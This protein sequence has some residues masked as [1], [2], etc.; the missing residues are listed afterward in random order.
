MRKDKACLRVTD[1]S[2]EVPS[3]LDCSPPP[4]H[5]PWH[6]SPALV[7][8]AHHLPMKASVWSPPRL[9]LTANNRFYSSLMSQLRTHLG[10]LGRQNHLVY[11][12]VI[13]SAT[14]DFCLGRFMG[15]FCF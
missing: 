9:R 11:S 14:S 4:P 3:P 6:H 7:A 5:G 12:L 8:P 10:V 13:K 1:L 2:A 15:I